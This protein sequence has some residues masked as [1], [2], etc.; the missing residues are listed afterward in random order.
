ME[1]TIAATRYHSTVDDDLCNGC[2]VC[3]DVCQVRAVEVDDD[4]AVVDDTSCIGCGLCA[5]HCPSD[6]IVMSER[7]GWKEP[8]GNIVEL[9]IPSSRNAAGCRPAGT[10]GRQG[11]MAHRVRAVR[12]PAGTVLPPPA[13]AGRD[14][15]CVIG[16]TG[17]STTWFFAEGCTRSG[18]NTFLCLGNSNPETVNAHVAYFLGD[19]SV[20]EQ[21][22]A[23]A[24]LFPLDRAPAGA[25]ANSA[26]PTA[27]AATSPWRSPRH[28][29]S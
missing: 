6:A 12:H 11:Q 26:I 29:G 18:F 8:V 5:S 28:W 1:G 23:V 24:P 15:H 2:E 27:S 3:R 17:A 20:L 7:E 9:A 14:G 13:P 19:G 22:Y 25:K 16:S 10:H 21:D 4:T